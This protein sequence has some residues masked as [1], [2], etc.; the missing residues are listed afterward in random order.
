MKRGVH[1]IALGRR[2]DDAVRRREFTRPPVLGNR[3]FMPCVGSGSIEETFPNQRRQESGGEVTGESQ[4]TH[5]VT[6]L[7]PL[8]VA[9]L[10]NTHTLPDCTHF[11]PVVIVRLIEGSLMVSRQ[12][13][14][15]DYSPLHFRLN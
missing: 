10:G 4:K 2:L 8:S 9:V 14:L 1:T 7:L 5:G 6:S 15:S 11:V 13:R 12:G 3:V